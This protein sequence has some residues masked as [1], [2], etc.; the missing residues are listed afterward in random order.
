MIISMFPSFSGT[1]KGGFISLEDATWQEISNI[2]RAGEAAERILVGSVKSLTYSG[3]TYRMRVVGVNHDLV[4]DPDTYGGFK[5][6]DGTTRAGVTFEAIENVSGTYRFG[7]TASYAN[8]IYWGDWTDSST[9]G[10]RLIQSTIRSD[11]FSDT[12]FIA[13]LDSGALTNLIVPVKKKYY[14]GYLS[15]MA[16]VSDKVFLL[17]LREMGLAP[18]SA[19]YYDEGETYVYYGGLPRQFDKIRS[20]VTNSDGSPASNTWTR[21]QSFD[22]SA[23]SGTNKMFTLNSTGGKSSMAC[24]GTTVSMGFAFCL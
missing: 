13:K 12:N 2:A 9:K 23:S 11:T 10:D 15:T 21:T 19:D 7:P 5:A 24:S 4:T 8:V 3:N 18:T 14:V 6:A 20:S 16:E 17:S 22:S 1:D